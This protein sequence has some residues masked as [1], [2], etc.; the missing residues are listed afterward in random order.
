MKKRVFV[1]F[2]APENLQKNVLLWQNKWRYLP[3]R[4]I[5]PK[6]LHITLVPPWYEEKIEQAIDLLKSCSKITTPI[7]IAFE[8]ICFGPKENQPRLIWIK[9]KSTPKLHLLKS[10]LTQALKQNEE[11][12]DF[13]PHLT[14]ARFKERDFAR[15]PVKKLAEKI[16]WRQKF[17]S[18]CLFESRLTPDG[19]EYEIIEEIKLSSRGS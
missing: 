4:F 19:A 7:E 2:N 18:F 13:L 10:K 11:K 8:E 9:G 5:A 14:I 16:N 1:G 12:R 3:A 6:N 15:F 17:D